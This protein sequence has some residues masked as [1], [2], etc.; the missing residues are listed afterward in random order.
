VLAKAVAFK[1]IKVL[2]T[3]DP[4]SAFI[5]KFNVKKVD[6]IS[7]LILCFDQLIVFF[8]L[9]IMAI[10]F[11]FIFIIITDLLIRVAEARL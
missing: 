3:I 2:S 7:Y 4:N 9:F 6:F 10:Q 8:V 5:V 1:F 11:I